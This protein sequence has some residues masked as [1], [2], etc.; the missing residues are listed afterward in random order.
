MSEYTVVRTTDTAEFSRRLTARAARF[1]A[2]L[3]DTIER[4]GSADSGADRTAAFLRDWAQRSG[5]PLLSLA[6]EPLEGVADH[7]GL[8]PLERDLL[9][10]AGLPE[11]H[12][13]LAGTFRLLHP[14]GEPHLT[15]G[16][17]ATVLAGADLDRARLRMLL[18][19]GPAVRYGVLRVTGRGGLFERSVEPAPRLWDAL[20]GTD[21]L[22]ATLRAVPVGDPVAGLDGWLTEP[23]VRRAAV[24]LRAG[25]PVTLVAAHN[26]EATALSRCA[27]LADSIGARL[28]AAR[29]A[30]GDAEAIAL[31]G[32]H[33]AARGA[34]PVVIVADPSPDAGAQ[35]PLVL[36]DLPG[37]AIVC[38]GA[39]AITL[40]PRRPMLVLPVAAAAVAHRRLA[41]RVALPGLDDAAAADLAARHPIDPAQIDQVGRDARAADATGPIDPSAVTG[42]IRR[43]CEMTLAAG[44]ALSTPAVAWPR[45]V[46]PEAAALQLRDAVA[47][48]RLRSVVLDDWG[49]REL[50]GAT[51]G[52]RL[53]FTGPPGTGK[54]LAAA[55]VATAAGTDLLR[56]DVSQLVSKWLGETEKNLARAFDAAER[57]QAVLLL[58]EADALFGARTQIS[59][60]HDRYA[61]Q[62]TAY[63][64]QRL[65]D[66]QGLVVLTTNLR[67]NIDP[68]FLRRLDFVVDFPLPDVDGR[69][70]LWA[71]HLPAEQVGPD[72]DLDV[73][74]RLYPVPGGWIRNAAVAAAFLAAAAGDRIRLAHLVSSM[75][76]EYEKAP[77]PF[78]GEPPRRRDDT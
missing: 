54:S 71:L 70:E 40:E 75:R 36:G 53:L 23:S 29:V 15:A 21:A 19:G 63:L 69:R 35:T 47:R 52:A 5:P 74:A 27:A 46:L 37:P 4:H 34:V 39:G 73:L 22:P 9:L 50:T 57:T 28:L 33:A 45:L 11:E 56:V 6:G 58:D 14:Y 7:F 24:L 16:L 30:A 66:F 12:E 55:A 25:R 1:A 65:D 78:P 67:H 51:C 41:W 61:N 3:A 38:A 62:E 72:V 49:M 59:D 68:A 13:G 42:L 48:L 44:I 20:H 64:L 2:A 10:L 18:S 43:R 60:A 76:R 77:L 32:V 8:S 26:D 31:L 17:A